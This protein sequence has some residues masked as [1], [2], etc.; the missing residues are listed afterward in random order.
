MA[1]LTWERV[2]F[3]NDHP[4]FSHPS[5]GTVVQISCHYHQLGPCHRG[6]KGPACQRRQPD[7]G[8]TVPATGSSLSDGGDP[9]PVTGNSLCEA[10]LALGEHSA[11]LGDPVL[12]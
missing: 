3:K 8:D 1:F 4:C 10:P 9:G 12:P 2:D 6:A 5:E 11:R 7:R